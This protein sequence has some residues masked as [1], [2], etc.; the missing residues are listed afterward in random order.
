MTATT[1]PSIRLVVGLGNPGQAYAAQ[2]H[3][4]GFWCVRRLARNWS[5]RF[6]SGRRA[7]VAEGQVDDEPLVLAKP[8]TFVNRSGD[9]AASLLQRYKL[10]PQEMLVI[11]DDLELAVGNIRLRPRGGDGGHNG[12]RDIIY[13]IDSEDFPRLRIGIG[14][15]RTAE[16]EPITD[17]DVVADYVL[18]EPEPEER[19]ALEAA[20]DRAA[21]AVACVFRE[22][23]AVAMNRYN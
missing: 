9:A 20:V 12:L 1:P 14:R 8:R 13:A 5:I 21:E 11:C 23:L 17:P 15:P 3:N 10:S 6:K 22:G 19:E 2:R 18:A 4:V 16:G 7:T